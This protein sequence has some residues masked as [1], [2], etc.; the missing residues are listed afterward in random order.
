MKKYRIC[1]NKGGWYK[2]QEWREKTIKY[3]IF[4]IKGFWNDRILYPSVILFKTKA[5]AEKEIIRLRVFDE[6]N[7]ENWTCYGEY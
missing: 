5:E 4:H 6:R 7:D 1:K 3:K 2:V